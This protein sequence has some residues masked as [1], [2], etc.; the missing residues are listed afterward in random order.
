MRIYENHERTS[1]RRAAPRSYYIP[2]GA[3]KYTLLNSI[4]DFEY[5]EDGDSVDV[6]TV[7]LHSS[8]AVPSTWQNSGVE[9][10]NYLNVNYP[11]PVD[12]PYVPMVNPV[13]VYEREITVE[14]IGRTY[15]VLEGVSSMAEIY[16]NGVYMGATQGSHLQAE[17]DIT[18]FVNV[19]K[20]TL[21][22]AVRKWCAG[23]Y[24]ESQ[25]AFRCNGIFRD[26]YLLERPIGHITDIDIRTNISGQVNITAAA[27][28]KLSVLDGEM[29]IAEGETDA[30]GKAEMWVDNPILWNAEKPYLY[31]VVLKKAGECIRQRIGFRE[32][33][34]SPRHEVCINGVPVKFKGVNHHDST[35]HGGWTMTDAELRRD[36]ELMK[37]LNINTVRTSHYPPSP[38]FMDWCDELGMYVILETDIEIHGFFNRHNAILQKRSYDVESGDWICSHP[39][40]KGEFVERMARA[41]ERDKNHTGII[42]WSLGNESGHGENHIAMIEYLR[43]KNDGRLIHAEDASRALVRWKGELVQAQREY[44]VAEAL[45][46]GESEA[47]AKLEWV[48]AQYDKARID[49]ERVDVFSA[50]YKMPEM[51]ERWASG[52]VQQPIFLCEFAHAMGN[53][54]GDIWDYTEVMYR[55][56]AFIGGCIWEWADHAVYRDGAYRYGGDFAGEKQHD[57]NFCCD[58]LVFPDRTFKAGTLE[59]KEA[60]APFRFKYLDGKVEVTNLF[61]FTNFAE[62]ELI[63]KVTA[64]GNTVAEGEVTLAISPHESGGFEIDVPTP[65]C[66]YGAYIEL[67]LRHNGNI[68]GTAGQKLYA[69]V[70]SLLADGTPAPVAD[71]EGYVVATSN[72]VTYRL[73]PKTGVFDSVVKDGK[74]ML[75]SPMVLTTFRATVDNDRK[76]RQMWFGGGDYTKSEN[77]NLTETHVYEMRVEDNTVTAD[78]SLAGAGRAPYFRGKIQYTFYDDGVNISLSGNIKEQ[79]PWLPR[80]GFELH[81]A[82]D[83]LPFDYY[84]RGAGENYIDMC[85][86][87]PWGHYFST[88]EQEYVPYIRPQEHGNHTA[89]RALNIAGLTFG[90]APEFECNVSKYSIAQLDSA[91]HT[92]EFVASGGTHLRIDYKNSGMGSASCGAVLDDKYKLSEKQLNFTFSIK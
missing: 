12:P 91:R 56:P 50:M 1:L 36:V 58:G 34:L 13:G 79:C 90:G 39:S 86:M 6:K 48:R 21:R 26:I 16:L 87:A 28:T 19:G 76:V 64:D 54:P 15:L 68:L 14:G 61:D 69:P 57:S 35:P 71:K 7:A 23:S 24:L 60:Y 40:W 8:I 37:S 27:E 49:A 25:D 65:E 59:V 43:E 77:I 67:S 3:A 32:I 53:S 41:Y 88:P 92:D 4:F 44:R 70:P 80:F 22:I 17:F 18:D 47:A 20:N 9:Q 42:M 29:L 81:F 38:K 31:T 75:K 33:T 66:M 72:G 84:G 74:E 73:S 51:V 62:C 11:F 82:E 5:F 63:W 52:E 89:V 30:E 83:N 78:I 46:E 10:P 55:Q 45:A 85:H 2:E